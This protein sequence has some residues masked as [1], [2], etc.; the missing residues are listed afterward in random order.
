MSLVAVKY[1]GNE[2]PTGIN[3]IEE[4]YLPT[5]AFKTQFFDEAGRRLYLV[6]TRQQILTEDAKLDKNPVVEYKGHV[7]KYNGPVQPKKNQPMRTTT[8]TAN[9]FSMLP[10]KT[11]TAG[12]VA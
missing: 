9:A 5:D 10:P 4:W 12:N 6:G 3:Q 2:G 1:I 8:V 7:F 11:G